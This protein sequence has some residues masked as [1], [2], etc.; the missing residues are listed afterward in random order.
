MNVA[1][2]SHGVKPQSSHLTLF[3]VKCSFRVMKNTPVSVR[4]TDE[5]REWLDAKAARDDRSLNWLI[6]KFVEQAR[7]AERK[8]RK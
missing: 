5:N 1:D 2:C 3:V 7:D 6:N 8:V 4:L